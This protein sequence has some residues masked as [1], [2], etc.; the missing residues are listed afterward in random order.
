LTETIPIVSTVSKSLIAIILEAIVKI[1]ILKNRSSWA[2]WFDA[3]YRAAG[4]KGIWNK[5]NSFNNKAIE[6]N[7][8]A[9]SRPLPIIN[10]LILK[11]TED[12]YTRYRV[13]AENWDKDTRPIVK[14]ELKPVSL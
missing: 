10:K 13:E 11:K 4:N 5:I 6:T 7:I 8:A 9:S 2:D 3:L 12:C 1:I 14:K